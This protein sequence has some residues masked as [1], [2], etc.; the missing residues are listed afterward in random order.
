VVIEIKGQW[1]KM[2]RR[3]TEY[4]KM[5]TQEE[6]LQAALQLEENQYQ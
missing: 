5:Q 2:E 1:K 4:L 3:A 6:A